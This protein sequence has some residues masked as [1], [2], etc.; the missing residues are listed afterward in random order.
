MWQTKYALAV[1]NNLGVQDQMFGHVVKVIS[2]LAL[3][4]A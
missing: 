1:A 4:S 2:S 3:C